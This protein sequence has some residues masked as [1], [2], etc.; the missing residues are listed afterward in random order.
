MATLRC[1]PIITRRCCK[2]SGILQ[3]SITAADL[4]RHLAMA[5]CRDLDRREQGW[6]LQQAI[7]DLTAISN[8]LGY[9]LVRT[10]ATQPAAEPEAV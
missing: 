6:E 10:S 4:V 9:V 1:A 3:A 8:Q 5:A 7:S 2:M